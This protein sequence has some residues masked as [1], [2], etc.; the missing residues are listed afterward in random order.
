M[1][2]PLSRRRFIRTLSTVLSGLPVLSR[3]GLLF[4][5]RRDDVASTSKDLSLWYR[6]PADQWTEALPIG[7]GRLG[8]MVFGGVGKEQIALN[9]DTLWSGAP[10]DWNN[11]GA[12]EFLSVVRQDVLEN[13]DYHA[14]DQV[15]RKMQGP[16]GTVRRKMRVTGG[17]PGRFAELAA[18]TTSR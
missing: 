10:R 16:R 12:K 14:A 13:K 5:S 11:P 2:I 4:A 6:Q 1:R 7:N 18:A 17:E 9:E 3:T 15:C 8:A